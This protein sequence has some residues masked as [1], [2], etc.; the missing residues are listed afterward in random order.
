MI[1]SCACKG[2]VESSG[3]GRLMMANEDTVKD[4]EDSSEDMVN[5]CVLDVMFAR[6]A[7][8]KRQL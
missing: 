2:T 7:A 6:D 5:T 3:W 4:D 1:C 8:V